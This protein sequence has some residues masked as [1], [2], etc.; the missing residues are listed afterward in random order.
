MWKLFC[1]AVAAVMLL[2]ITFPLRVNS[3]PALIKARN[4]SSVFSYY[5]NGARFGNVPSPVD[6]QILIKWTNTALKFFDF[7]RCVASNIASSEDECF[8]L[9][10][11][12]RSSVAVYLGISPSASVNKIGKHEN[13]RKWDQKVVAIFPDSSTPKSGGSH[14]AILVLDPYPNANFGHLVAVFYIDFQV[15]AKRCKE[16]FQIFTTG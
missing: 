13:F 8:Q 16:E 12:E 15:E 4:Y 1:V 9:N 2:C 10:Q 6:N 5:S 7:H 3:L 14:D 11:M